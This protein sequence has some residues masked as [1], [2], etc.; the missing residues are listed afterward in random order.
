[1]GAFAP[2]FFIGLSLLKGVSNKVIILSCFK[3]I[4]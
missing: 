2:I 3:T 1:M 4:I